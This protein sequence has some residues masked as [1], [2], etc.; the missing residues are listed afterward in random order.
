M[1]AKGT[2]QAPNF[3]NNDENINS[4]FTTSS[5]SDL[6]DAQTV[7]RSSGINLFEYAIGS[8]LSLNQFDSKNLISRMFKSTGLINQSSK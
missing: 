8:N 5:K 7:V 4:N 3:F 6:Q 1:I 2:F